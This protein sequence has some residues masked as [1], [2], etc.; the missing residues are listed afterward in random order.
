MLR[1]MGGKS[2]ATKALAAI[3]SYNGFLYVPGPNTC[4]TDTGGTTPATPGQQVAFLKDTAD[5]KNLTQG[6]AGFRPL[7]QQDATGYY[8][9]FDGI[10][11]RLITSG[12]AWFNP[13]NDYF[14]SACCR[15]GTTTAKVILGIGRVT[16]TP[17]FAN[18]FFNNTSLGSN[19][20]NN[21]GGISQ[22]LKTATVVN[23]DIVGTGKRASNLLSCIV[24]NVDG[25]LVSTPEAPI[26]ADLGVMGANY[27]SGVYSAYLSGRIYGSVILPAA[28]STAD[29]LLINKYLGS[30]RG[31]VI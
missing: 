12:G 14:M 31:V 5:S 22:S 10:D 9:A 28:P 18:L 19:L 3:K 6:A 24:N 2:L 16:S 21:A 15:T 29:Q 17:A 8:L 25:S 23:V 11:D 27:I 26:P 13:E 7:L 20:R 30:L 4:F 1:P